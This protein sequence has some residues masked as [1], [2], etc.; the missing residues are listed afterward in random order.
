NWSRVR[1]P[2][3]NVLFVHNGYLL[4]GEPAEKVD[5]AI[6]ESDRFSTAVERGNA[7]SR[8]GHNAA[9]A[10]I[11]FHPGGQ[12]LASAGNDFAMILWDANTGERLRILEAPAPELG[13]MEGNA[14]YGIAF[15]PDGRTGAV[16]LL[17][18]G[19]GVEKAKFWDV[20]TGREIDGRGES[21]WFQDFVEAR[22]EARSGLRFSPDG[23][24]S[25]AGSEDGFVKILRVET[26]ERLG[27][28]PDYLDS[29]EAAILISNGPVVAIAE[30][31]GAVRLLE[32]STGG[33]LQRLQGHKDKV[34][35]AAFSADGSTVVTGSRDN[36]ARIWNVRSG[37]LLR[38]IDGQADAVVA[39]AV[40]S[41]GDTV[42]A[43]S[44]DGSAA[45]WSGRNGRDIVVRSPGG[46]DPPLENVSLSADGRMLLTEF[47]AADRY[48]IAVWNIETGERLASGDV[49]SAILSP[50]GDMI[51]FPVSS[52]GIGVWKIGEGKYQAVVGSR[53]EV[54]AFAFS[55]DSRL[56]ATVSEY[57][58]IVWDVATGGKVI[59][60]DRHDAYV[61]DP[62][63]ID[64]ARFSEDGAAVVIGSEE[65]AKAWDIGS[66]ERVGSEVRRDPAIDV[67]FSPDGRM[68]ATRHW[69]GDVRIWD[70]ASNE[71]LH[72][73]GL[74]PDDSA[75]MAFGNDGELL[76]IA[77]GDGSIVLR[78]TGT[79][80]ERRAFSAGESGFRGVQFSPDDRILAA[81]SRAG[82]ARFWDIESGE[83]LHVVDTGAES[84]SERGDFRDNL[85][86]FSPDGGTVSVLAGSDRYVYNARIFDAGSFRE[87]LALDDVATP[88][89][90][91]PD[92]E[93][94]SAGLYDGSVVFWDAGTG[95]GLRGA[96]HGGPGAQGNQGDA[97]FSREGLR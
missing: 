88:V 5:T 60:I 35:S 82:E 90:Y 96:G 95:R 61:R 31:G 2:A 85:I 78:D 69:T 45:V 52:N 77:S 74:E 14:D 87:V 44:L 56:I 97:V 33:P 18:H 6:G 9:V 79:G 55:P 50:N 11:A 54:E 71:A 29:A 17:D 38:V 30:E 86:S 1:T 81:V 53:G 76:A 36:T 15:S 21:G 58:V 7:V 16:A 84:D 37:E 64:W 57:R 23:G 94:A 49:D 39:V 10:S 13:I 89:A 28:R 70:A 41:D 62:S 25:A 8:T 67:A 66:G 47:S 59:G 34:V 42:A 73:L 68:F 27:V 24:I 51:A 43:G 22:L 72:A 63:S 75:E 20:A 12:F 80:K 83:L 3:G 26:G 48:R 93:T 65:F 4:R 46:R 19:G 91:S 92:G 32:A 40:D